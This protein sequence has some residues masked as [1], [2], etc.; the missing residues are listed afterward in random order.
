MNEQ[1][2][3][4][5]KQQMAD[6]MERMK[7]E[8]TSNPQLPVR[9]SGVTANPI[10]LSDAEAQVLAQRLADSDPDYADHRLRTSWALSYWMFK[11]HKRELERLLAQPIPQVD[12][13]EQRDAMDEQ[14]RMFDHLRRSLGLTL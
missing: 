7:V 11:A 5:L 14:I 8:R 4:G 3:P 13:Q 2:R 10:D 1:N 12:T 6:A 9:I